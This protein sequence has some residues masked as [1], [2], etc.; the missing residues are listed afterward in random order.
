MLHI[1]FEY[2]AVNDL[3]PLEMKQ[4]MNESM[5]ANMSVLP[6]ISLQMFEALNLTDAQ[7]Q[8]MEKIKKEFEPEFEKNL[9]DLIKG[10]TILANKALDEFIGQKLDGN[11]EGFGERMAAVLKKLLADDQEYKKIYTE[12]QSQGQSFAT[13]FKEKIFDVLTD[14]QWTRL[15]DLID[16]PPEYAKVFGTALKRQLETSEPVLWRSG[17]TA[18]SSLMLPLTT[19]RLHFLRYNI[20]IVFPPPPQ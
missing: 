5:L 1:G 12:I 9:E 19:P 3:L 10:Q 4:K 8:Q 18:A 17:D 20:G 6:I 2:N 13:R 14:E 16:N 7:K 15:L 11:V